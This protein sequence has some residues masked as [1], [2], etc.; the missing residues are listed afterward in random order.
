MAIKING[1]TIIPN[2]TGD[3]TDGNTALGLNSLDNLT[4]GTNN[5]SYGVNTLT[6]LTDGTN[7]IAIGKDA[8][9]SI[10]TG[11][12]NTIIGSYAG[13]TDLQNTLVITAGT[14]ER[15]KVDAT[16][17]YVNGSEF[18][19]GGAINNIFWEN[20][21]SITT[22]YTITS[23]KNAGTFGPVSIDVGV[24]VTIPV[25]SVWSIV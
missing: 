15:L 14:T 18:T 24:V 10:T 7:N 8:G 19:G 5:T 12:N 3:I 23:G 17:L 13:T 1:N 4:T 25:N 11:D 22:N 20:D 2:S 6:A 21:T 16:G 9:S